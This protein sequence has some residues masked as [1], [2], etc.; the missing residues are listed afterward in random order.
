M[1]REQMQARFDP[2]VVDATEQLAE[3]KDI[4]RSE[5]MRRA[6]REGLMLYG[7]EIGAES[8]QQTSELHQSITP[9][10]ALNTLLL[11]LVV[12]LQLGVV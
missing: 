3:D 10:G 7:Y 2:D 1:P 8:K 12:S 6:M 9:L 5:A 11:L 4:S